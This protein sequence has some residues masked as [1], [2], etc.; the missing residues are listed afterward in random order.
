MG[1][2]RLREGGGGKGRKEGVLVQGVLKWGKGSGIS[3]CAFDSGLGFGLVAFF[4]RVAVMVMGDLGR[5]VFRFLE[6]I[7]AKYAQRVAVAGEVEK[8]LSKIS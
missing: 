8:K 2:V 5:D 6:W 7:C 1:E 4:G 3:R